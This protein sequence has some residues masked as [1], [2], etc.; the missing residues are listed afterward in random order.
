ME[1]QK[2]KKKVNQTIIA[3]ILK[4]LKIKESFTTYIFVSPPPPKFKLIL[5][6]S[7]FNVNV[8]FHYNDSLFILTF[9]ETNPPNFKLGFLSAK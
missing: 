5:L 1:L 7:R 3:N 6:F 9:M 2:N 8:E 4:D